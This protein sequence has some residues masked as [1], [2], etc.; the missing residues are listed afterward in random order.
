MPVT[1]NLLYTPSGA[2]PQFEVNR[3]GIT[4]TRMVRIAGADLSD[5]VNE[6]FPPTSVTGATILINPGSPMP[7]YPF[8]TAQSMSM[9]PVVTKDADFTRTDEEAIDW[10]HYDCTITYGRN[11]YTLEDSDEDNEDP[12]EFLKHSWSLGGEYI[13]IPEA[14]LVW[15]NGDK[16]KDQS[17]QAGKFLPTIE[18]QITWPHVTDPPFAAMRSSIGRVNNAAV[19]F[20]TGTIAIETLLFLGASLSRQIMSDGARAWNVS[21]RFSERSVGTAGGGTG[22]WNH[23]LRVDANNAGWFRLEANNGQTAD[24]GYA[25]ADAIYEQVN[26]DLL[27]QSEA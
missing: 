22:G 25:A 12:T 17:L 14:G 5:F 3:E 20:Q 26:F 13:T 2:F 19:N 16:V 9:Q 21:Y 8:L 15:D 4:A 7:D 24:D 11:Q 6:I 10:E 1:T 23:F 27:F 18:H